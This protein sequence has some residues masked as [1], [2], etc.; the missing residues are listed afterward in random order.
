MA[1][2][3][4]DAK[5]RMQGAQ[6]ALKRELGSIRTG[7]AN[8]HILDRIEVEYYGAMT[9][10]KQVASISVPEARILLITPFDKSA[11]EEI[12]RAINMSDLGLNP[13]SDGNIVRLAIPQMTEEG[14][15]DLAKQVKAE[16]EKAKVSIRNVRRDA[17]DT[18]KKDKELPED[19]VRNAEDDVQ[20]LTDDNIK[21]IDVIAS[22]KEKE[23]L[24]I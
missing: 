10:L 9:P 22:E 24:T 13:A 12:V 21:A 23:L 11:L 8:P 4:T 19:D 18:V 20:K 5:T 2:N 7:R 17:M 1:F 16:A 14:R 15:K 3:L 6:D